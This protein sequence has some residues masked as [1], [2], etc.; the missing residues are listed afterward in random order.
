MLSPRLNTTAERRN[1][2]DNQLRA[3]ID[4]IPALVWLAASDGAA[5]HVNRRWLEYTGFSQPQ[6]VGWGWT[7]AV[8]PDDRSRLTAHWHRLLRGGEPRELEARI[9]RFDGKYRWFLFGAEPLCDASGARTG[10]CGTHIDVDDRRR[11]EE[12]ARVAEHDLRLILDN[13]PALVSTATANGEIAFAN[14]RLLEYVGASLEELQDWPTFVHE[15]DR[16]TVA[17]LW[18][19]SLKTG[20]SFESEHRLRRADGLYRWFHARAVPVYATQGSIVRWYNLLTDI[21][22]RKRSEDLLRASEQQFRVTVD[23]IPGLV[24][25]LNASGE[26][27]LV[28]RGVMDYFGV[29][30]DELQHWATGDSV[31]PDDVPG[32]IA[33]WQRAISSG[34]LLETEHRLR[35]ADGMYRWFQLRA[36][37]WLDDAN[38]IVRWYCLITDIHD[39]KTAE[40]ALR[41]SETFLLEVQRLSR[42][43]GWRYD[44]ASDVVESSP[45]IQRVHAVQPGE[46]I[47]RPAFWFERIH[48]DDRPRVQA[49]FERCMREQTEY[50]TGYR[51][52]LPDGSIRYQYATGHPV[53]NDTGEVVAVIGASMDMTEHWLTTNEL[54]RAADALRLLQAKL[55]HAAHIATVGELAASIAHEVN[56]PLA[57]VVANGHACLRWLSAM[58][59]NI[60]K[61]AEAAKRI[62][63]DGKDAGEIVRRVR[64]LFKRAAADKV[65]LDINQLIREVLHLLEADTKRRHVVVDVALE[66]D[67]PEVLGDRIQLQQLVLNLML[68]ALEAVDPVVG[69]AKQLS[70]RSSRGDDEDAVIEIADNGIGLDDPERAFEPFFTTKEEGLGMGLAICRSI[71]AAHGGTLSAERNVGLGTTFTFKLALQADVS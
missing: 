62:I 30:L 17:A 34:E 28:N 51:N 60:E 56:Q 6:A 40:D 59:P 48:P 16:S 4:T 22:D 43:G 21:E 23:G 66:P 61:A 47:S 39:R 20:Q 46:D 49:E 10:W 1:L 54:E 26:I 32:V 41:R 57:A 38:R 15:D 69:R 44:L 12:T 70:V 53:V 35:R 7:A 2:D 45:E 55:S 11:A 50:R 52:V 5:V 71:V 58:P 24:A 68:N 19:R 25:I 42:T 36:R 37:P 27:E 63:T 33:L 31:H 29:S 18:Q 3:V 14:Q 64:S 8:H 9:Q 65:P 67:L 13:I